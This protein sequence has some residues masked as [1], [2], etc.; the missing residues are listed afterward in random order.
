MM[1]EFKNECA[2]A[3]LCFALLLVFAGIGRGSV[4]LPGD[5]L[6]V[7]FVTNPGSY[8]CLGGACDLLVLMP[9]YSGAGWLGVTSIEARLYDGATLLGTL[10]TVPF[11]VAFES[12][13]SLF[14]LGFPVVDFTSIDDGTIDGVIDFSVVGGSD[15]DLELSQTYVRL[16]HSYGP[17]GG[18][19]DSRSATVV[20]AEII[21]PVPEPST[22]WLVAS[23]CF[24]MLCKKAVA[25]RRRT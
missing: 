7:E 3:L 14:D 22:V 1:L 10:N 4:F 15:L 18:E 17:G 6:R 8:P 5:V 20:S 11:V 16:G 9:G 12:S 19:Y 2:R 21:G 13:T 25:A 23:C 24:M